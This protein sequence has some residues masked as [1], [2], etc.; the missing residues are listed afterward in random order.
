MIVVTVDAAGEASGALAVRL[1]R[2]L[3]D[4]VAGKMQRLF[5]GLLGV[6]YLAFAGAAFE[7]AGRNGL[8][9]VAWW[10]W[11][12][13]GAPLIAAVLLLVVAATGCQRLLL[14]VGAIAAVAAPVLAALFLLARNGETGE[15]AL[16]AQP[17]MPGITLHMSAL[18]LVLARRYR[19][20]LAA[21]VVT[22]VVGTTCVVVA[23]YGAM[24]V[25]GAAQI[26]WAV[27][28]GIVY[29][30]V[31]RLM[32]MTA[33]RYDREQ[34]RTAHALEVD[35]WHSRRGREEARIDALVHDQII[36]LL[37]SIRPGPVHP[38]AQAYA[39]GVLDTIDS[40]HDDA[41]DET[42]ATQSAEAA[43]RRL[44]A[45]VTEY[46]DRPEIVEDLSAPRERY[47]RE[48][49]T[50]V[51][52]AAGEAVRNALRHAG[53]EA[54]ILAVIVLGDG[55]L[56]VTVVDDGPGFDPASVRP[57]AMG[58][59]VAIEGR[60]QQLPGGSAAVRTELGTGTRVRVQWS[61]T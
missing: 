27:A 19:W 48:A 1:R 21:V 59:A 50:A 49:V 33:D 4:G 38:D 24:T 47:P 18:I 28:V 53:P 25:D 6:G 15:S 61:R 52:D 40:W 8:V 35:S 13:S 11:V 23:V 58:L 41:D 26:V 44:R 42:E 5:A 56:G 34:Q 37:N 16:I 32:M 2:S 46:G 9:D 29:V 17:V 57:T 10:R 36:A 51:A 14:V 20:A 12:Y 55:V 60:M 54:G 3:A 43:L 7:A 31:T 39:R 22:S 45:A 30:A